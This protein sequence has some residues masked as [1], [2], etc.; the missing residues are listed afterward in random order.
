MKV[1]EV[2]KLLEEK[3]GIDLILTEEAEKEIEDAISW[4]IENGVAKN[5]KEAMEYFSPAAEIINEF[6]RKVTEI[7][8]REVN[9]GVNKDTGT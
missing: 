9:N 4:L 5:R 7:F 6:C 8:Q 2:F 1:E 3:L